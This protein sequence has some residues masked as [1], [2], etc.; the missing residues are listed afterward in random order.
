MSIRE[1][2]LEILVAG[3]LI[4]FS[5]FL[6]WGAARMPMGPVALPG[7]GFMPAAL[8]ALIGIVGVLLL[9][10]CMFAGDSADEIARLGNRDVLVVLV[11]LCGSAFLF[12]RIGY[13]ATSAAMLF[14]LF[15][16]WSPL[17]L[18]RSLAASVA[19]AGVSHVFFVQV[20][21]VQLPRFPLGLF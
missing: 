3:L 20:L 9:V 14:V 2:Y 15:W 8:S 1:R 18:W 12:E 7:P 17:G 5:A 11:A 21:G 16:S 19:S 10:G 4:A 13:L 6:A